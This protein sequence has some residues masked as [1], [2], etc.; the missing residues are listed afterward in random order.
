[1]AIRVGII[2][3]HAIE[4]AHTEALMEDMARAVRKADA[5]F[6]ARWPGPDPGNDPP[7]NFARYDEERADL[8]ETLADLAYG[9]AGL[10]LGPV[11]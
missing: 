6:D 10:V 7:G 1:M 4:A 3:R 2:R 5:A 11:Q 9:M 8:N